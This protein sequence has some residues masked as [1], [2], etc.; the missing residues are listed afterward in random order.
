MAGTLIETDSQGLQWSDLRTRATVVSR[1]ATLEMC[2]R[3]AA[4]IPGNIIEFGVADGKS[5]RVLRR[6]L[7]AVE[8]DGAPRKT[9]YACDSFEG[10]REKF[11]NAEVGAF[12]CE[13]PKI[14]GVQ[15]VKGYFEDSLTPALAKQVGRVAFASLDAD[16]YSSTI[17]A[18]R[19]LTPL[20]GT[21]TL[22]LF[23]EYLGEKASE[24]R[25]HEDWMAETGMQTV[26]LATFLR[27]PSGW[28]TVPDHRV[29]VQVIGPDELPRLKRER[30]RG[31]FLQRLARG[32]GLR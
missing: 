9:I 29:L 14:P 12:A 1:H 25:A 15:I 27:N 28:G 5:T 30:R 10:L 24:K 26:P 23:D 6:A 16:L 8:R 4:G 13:P 18:L 19:W 31:A 21:G 2:V 17:C 20:I 32:V 3:L 7:T 22:L 11:E